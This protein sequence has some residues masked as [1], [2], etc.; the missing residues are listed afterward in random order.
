MLPSILLAGQA[1]AGGYYENFP[2]VP[3]SVT[4]VYMWPPNMY[5]IELR[6]LT[7]GSDA[8]LHVQGLGGVSTNEGGPGEAESIQVSGSIAEP[9]YVIVHAAST[10]TAGEADLYVNNKYFDRVAFGGVVNTFY[11]LPAGTRIFAGH[12]AGGFAHLQMQITGC[13]PG[14][15]PQSYLVETGNDLAGPN[16]VEMELPSSA[17]CLRVITGGSDPLIP[18]NAFD[19]AYVPGLRLYYSVDTQD[20]DGDGLDASLEALLGSCDAHGIDST[21]P[22]TGWPCDTYSSLDSDGDGIPD[23]DEIY[24]V[25]AG[26]ECLALALWGAD[27]AQKDVF[28]EVD[29]DNGGLPATATGVRAE[30]GL[31]PEYFQQFAEAFLVGPSRSTRNPNNADGI[32]VHL[33]LDGTTSPEM[34]S[35][36]GSRVVVFDSSGSSMT[37]NTSG[38]CAGWDDRSQREQTDLAARYMV[39]ACEG[40]HRSGRASANGLR[41]LRFR[42][43]TFTA[44]TTGAWHLLAHE[45]GHVLELSHGGGSDND[46]VAVHRVSMMSYAY[47][48]RRYVFSSGLRADGPLP[49][50]FSPTSLCEEYPFLEPSVSGSMVDFYSNIDKSG[51][52]WVPQRY[53]VTPDGAVDWNRDGVINDCASPVEAPLRWAHDGSAQNHDGYRSQKLIARGTSEPWE[54]G[55]SASVVFVDAPGIED[56]YVFYPRDVTGNGDY[57][58]AWQRLPFNGKQCPLPR[59]SDQGGGGPCGNF[60]SEIYTGYPARTIDTVF[61]NGY[62]YIV[63][64]YERGPSGSPVNDGRIA[65]RR[66]QPGEG[67]I[68]A[69]ASLSWA[70]NERAVGRPVVARDYENGGFQIYYRR[71]TDNLLRVVIYDSAGNRVL[72]DAPMDSAT[73]RLSVEDIGVTRNLQNG[74]LYVV[75]SDNTSASMKF[76]RR[77]GVQS[78]TADTQFTLPAASE[79]RLGS[80]LGISWRPNEL[81]LPTGSGAFWLFWAAQANDQIRQM[82]FDGSTDPDRLVYGQRRF[83][84]DAA[85][86]PDFGFDIEFLDGFGV[87]G[88]ETGIA[89]GAKHIKFLPYAVEITDIPLRDSDDFA[90]MDLCRRVASEWAAQSVDHPGCGNPHQS[91]Q[92]PL[93]SPPEVCGE[94]SE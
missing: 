58:I 8:V 29:W 39:Y 75:Y 32:R 30:S 53:P 46:N 47:Q 79:Y 7:P 65:V 42:A 44:S 36:P 80:G 3:I 92:T 52:R 22:L 90:A 37:T 15:T 63:S 41:S 21:N 28:V 23:H 20:G 50:T 71:A 55:G 45:L 61:M 83:R 73:P 67:G 24:G 4:P 49:G 76:L 93:P 56:V 69:Q 26:A 6:N 68:V 9:E 25:C 14:F 78:W 38:V 74:K 33:D 35:I 27:I 19:P 70:T 89:S 40:P 77:D 91:P 85:P 16:E 81:S 94:D 12:K 5:T 18:V 17:S 1:L 48:N 60:D 59:D 87:L 86:G 62:I 57:R 10:L 51:S 13:D 72:T 11:G 43:P 64:R 31:D 54:V 82:R 66:F 2:D 84:G 88:V 34:F